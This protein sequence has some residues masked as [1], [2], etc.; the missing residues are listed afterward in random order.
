[1]EQTYYNA[2]HVESTYLHASS[3]YSPGRC[4]KEAGKSQSRAFLVPQAAVERVSIDL[5]RE[6]PV[7]FRS[8]QYHRGQIAIRNTLSQTSSVFVVSLFTGRGATQ[9]AALCT[10]CS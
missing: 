6:S 7:F 8:I 10:S 3:Y 1:M 2:R 4:G 5:R 9:S